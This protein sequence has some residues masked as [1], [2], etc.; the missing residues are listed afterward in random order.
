[1]RSMA[2]LVAA[3]VAVLTSA[4]VAVVRVHAQ[5]PP[6]IE[7]ISIV[8]QPGE[9]GRLPRRAAVPVPRPPGAPVEYQTQDVPVT[10]QSDQVATVASD[11]QTITITLP[12]GF[13]VRAEVTQF[14]GTVPLGSSPCPTQAGSPNITV[15]NV[16]GGVTIP[17]SVQFTATPAPS[18]APTPI[19]TPGRTETVPLF[20]GCNNVALTWPN[21]T[22][23]TDVAAAVAPAEALVAIWRFNNATQT[24]QGFS[25][26]F[27]GASDLT[28]VNRTDAVFVC[29]REPGMLRRPVI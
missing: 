3:V 6:T 25:R 4:I 19:P 23:T 14:A 12:V 22:P 7:P 11:G 5:A 16:G 26:Q 21:G 10:N 17:V 13:T 28:T 29:M 18:P 20:R 2:P 8:L 1:M 9:A 24:F 27:P 15:C